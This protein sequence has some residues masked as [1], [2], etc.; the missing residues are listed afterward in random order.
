MNTFGYH[1]TFLLPF[2]ILIFFFSPAI[3]PPPYWALYLYCKY[4]TFYLQELLCS[5]CG[6]AVSHGLSWK[7]HLLVPSLAGL[8]MLSVSLQVVHLLTF[9][10]CSMGAFR[11]S[12]SL[13]SP[14][15]NLLFALPLEAHVFLLQHIWNSGVLCLDSVA[16]F[17]HLNTIFID[18]QYLS[19]HSLWYLL[20]LELCLAH[21]IDL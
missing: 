14:S 18:K 3:T 21:V 1:Q 6:N 19:D 11:G 2:R 12:S 8:C 15:Y 7:I 5:D 20:C 10:V 13:T 9:Q 16:C 4:C 17:S